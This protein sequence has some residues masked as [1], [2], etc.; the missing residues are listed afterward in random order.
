MTFIYR[1]LLGVRSA[2]CPVVMTS[3]FVNQDQFPYDKINHCRRG[4]LQRIA[5]SAGIRS[6]GYITPLSRVQ[7][8]CFARVV[9]DERVSLIHA[10][11][12]P[13]GIEILPVAK[14]HGIPL[15]VTF[16]GFDA[17]QLLQCRAYRRQLVPLL[18]YAAVITVSARMAKRLT[19]LGANPDRMFVH[20][21]GVPLDSFQITSRLPIPDK[22]A[23]R[24]EIVLLQVASFVE[25]KGHRYTLQAFKTLLESYSNCRLVLIG[26]GPLRNVCEAQAHALGIRAKVDFVSHVPSKE[27]AWRMSAA[28]V[29]VH[30]SVTAR[31][32]DQEGIP[33][34]I[35]EAMACGLPI[36]STDHAGIEEIVTDGVNG[37]LV[38]ERDV[39]AYAER[40]RWLLLSR[41]PMGNRSREV[42]SIKLDLVR[43][44]ATLAQ[45]YLKLQAGSDFRAS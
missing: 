34:A 9:S 28:D 39:N 20:H 10:H 11:F 41:E 12:G 29:F 18:K 7:R 38:G 32:G 5:H 19:D 36:V 1:Q 25:K 6:I 42:A 15:L 44:N 40:L 24:K 27:V 2:V 35:M 13:S 37:Y 23:D 17:S 30:H 16:H 26:S 8:N 31:D 22:V 14:A 21:I 4:T 45:I 3:E 43:Q 33:T